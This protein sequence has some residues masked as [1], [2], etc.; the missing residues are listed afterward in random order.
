M[1]KEEFLC[2]AEGINDD[3]ESSTNQNGVGIMTVQ[4][5]CVAIF[6]LLWLYIRY[7]V[8]RDD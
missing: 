6:R 3:F 5:I 2:D 8:S 4:M 7:R 1:T